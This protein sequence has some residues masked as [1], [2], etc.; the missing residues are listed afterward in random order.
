MMFQQ[1]N[2]RITQN[3]KIYSALL[4]VKYKDLRVYYFYNS[5]NSFLTYFLA[6]DNLTSKLFTLYFLSVQNLGSL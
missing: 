2:C 4:E 5:H 6:N 1:Q 3:I